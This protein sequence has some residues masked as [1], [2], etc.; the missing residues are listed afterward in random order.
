MKYLILIMILG[1]TLTHAADL[2]VSFTNL[3]SDKG[4]IYIAMWDSA[5]GFPKDYNQ[6]IE[7]IT[8]AAT[9]TKVKIENLKNG[10]YAIA[11]F[12]D[13]NSDQTLN[14]NAMGIPKEAFGFSNNS[15][16]LF[17]P[18]SFNKAKFKIEGKDLS[19]NIEFKYF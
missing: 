4:Q 11:I 16:L 14:T 18:P 17:G 8:I 3:K 5:Q 6:A 15:R 10:Y 13:K 9:Q 7:T 1:T 12:H 19:K 2:T